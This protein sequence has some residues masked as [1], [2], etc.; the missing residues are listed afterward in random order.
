VVLISF[1]AVA[2]LLETL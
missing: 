2:V 1:E